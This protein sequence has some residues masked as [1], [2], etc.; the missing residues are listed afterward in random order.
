MSISLKFNENLTE[1]NKKRQKIDLIIDFK[2][3]LASQSCVSYKNDIGYINKKYHPTKVDIMFKKKIKML[4]ANITEQSNAFL[5]TQ[6]VEKYVWMEDTSAKTFNFEVQSTDNEVENVVTRENLSHYICYTSYKID[7]SNTRIV[8]AA[9]NM[10]NFLLL[11]EDGK[12]YYTHNSI[13]GKEKECSIHQLNI[14]EMNIKEQ[15]TSMSCGYNCYVIATNSR[16][17]FWGFIYNDREDSS[18]DSAEYMCRNS[19][20]TFDPHKKFNFTF[21]TIVKIACGIDYTLALTNEGKL[22][23]WGGPYFYETTFCSNHSGN[24]DISPIQMNIINVKNLSDIAV[25]NYT[26]FVKSSKNEL[27]YAWGFIFK[28]QYKEPAVCEY[29]NAFDISNSMT[30]R[31]PISVADEFI[32]EEFH[33]LKDLETAFNDQSTSDLTIMVEKQSI[34][35]HKVILKIRSTY[36]RSMFQTNYV[37]NRQRYVFTKKMS[38]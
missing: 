13:E 12:I 37:E 33:I 9:T 21:K 4:I 24:N 6:D 19:W 27:V 5:V 16:T 7:W 18:H 30:A 3:W 26:N 15:I 23:C 10:S 35:V 1:N 22:Y 2:Y 20:C 36:F 28:R 31:S 25:I 38:S 17:F 32:N 29:T 11:T 8:K 14:H 34:Y